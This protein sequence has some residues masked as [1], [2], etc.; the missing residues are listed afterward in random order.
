MTIS[1]H[2]VQFHMYRLGRRE[3]VARLFGV[4]KES[5]REVFPR[6]EMERYMSGELISIGKHPVRKCVVCETARHIEDFVSKSS[7]KSGCGNT[8]SSCRR[9]VSL[10]KM[11]IR[12]R[13]SK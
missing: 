5:L 7:N 9:A 6:S 10:H 2:V 8:C 12:V 3:Y 4:N 13:K 11:Y 1:A